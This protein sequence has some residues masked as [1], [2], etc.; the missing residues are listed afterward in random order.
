MRTVI[1]ERDV[2]ASG[3]IRVEAG[4]VITPSAR[5]LARE[6]GVAIVEVAREQLQKTAPP[7]KTVAM[8][9][10][11]GGFRMKEA[12]KALVTELG[13]TPH[14]VGV[15][16]EKPADYP[17]IALAVAELVAAGKAKLGIVVDG[18]G[19][20][21]AMAAN[22]VPGVR[23]ALCYDRASARNSREHNDSNVLTL[24][25]RL[26]TESQA[27]DVVRVWLGTPFAGGRHAARVNKITEIEKKYAN[28]T[29]QNLKN[30]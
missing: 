22:K 25:G 1:T 2:P 27:S 18:A 24:G 13:F 26:L 20:G 10:D 12:I 28:W 11:H 14:D 29:P 4:A 23:A 30:S 3:E 21:S 16:E 5:D 9:A 6:R 8:G 17:D 19:I 15:H 7:D